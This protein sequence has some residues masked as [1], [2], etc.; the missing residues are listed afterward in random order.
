[1]HDETGAFITDSSLLHVE[2][3]RVFDSGDGVS[4]NLG[5]MNW[6]IRGVYFKYIRDDCVEDDFLYSGTIDD[7][8]FDGCYD[9]ISARAWSGQSPD[10]GDGSTNLIVMKN[11]LLRLQEMDAA[12]SAGP[13]PNHNAFW[14]WDP[15]APQVALYNNV[16]RADADSWEGNGAGMYMAPPPGKLADCENNTMVWLGAGPFPEPLPPPLMASPALPLP[17]IK[18]Y[19]TR[20]WRNGKPTTPRR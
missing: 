15:K 14:K 1:M 2:N 5:G 10:P 17:P 19:G 8:L 9:G 16:F 12:Y 18:A 20:R 4:I 11:S 13:L 6:T 7:S 3:T